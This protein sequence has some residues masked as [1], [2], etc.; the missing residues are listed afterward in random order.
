MRGVSSGGEPCG[1]NQLKCNWVSLTGC[2]VNPVAALRPWPVLREPALVQGRGRQLF[3]PRLS[4]G[5]PTAA[6]MGSGHV[7]L[8]RLPPLRPAPL[9]LGSMAM[10]SSLPPS[11][12]RL[13]VAPAAGLAPLS[14]SPPFQ[15]PPPSRRQLRRDGGGGPPPGE[16]APPLP[17]PVQGK[18]GPRA[19]ARRGEIK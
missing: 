9:L 5:A 11:C 18:D 6:E 15:P 3:P 2:T 19:A 4:S 10:A 12:L 7:E 14:L 8:L 16:P 1:V 17:A 13:G